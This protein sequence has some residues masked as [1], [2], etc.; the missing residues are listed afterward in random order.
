VAAV[1]ADAFSDYPWTRWTVDGR[2]HEQR[3]ERLQRLAL[4]HVGLPYGEVWVLE[5]GGSIEAAAVWMDSRAQVP[6][7]AWADMAEE[8][9]LLAGDRHEHARTAEQVVSFLRPSIPHRYLATVGTTSRTRRQGLGTAVLAP[10]LDAADADGTSAYL[11]TS[12][13]ENLGFYRTLGFEVVNEVQLEGGP[14][15][16]AMLRPTTLNRPAPPRRSG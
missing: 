6:S 1:L 4:E 10:G 16:W 13:S 11:E 5:R 12:S 15:V 9:R 2:D 7:A 8:Q 14:P 3:I